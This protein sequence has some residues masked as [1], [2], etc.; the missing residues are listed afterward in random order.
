MTYE[1]IAKIIEEIA[2]AIGTPYYEK[3]KHEKIIQNLL[4]NIV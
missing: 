4:Q 3:G 2:D 1:E